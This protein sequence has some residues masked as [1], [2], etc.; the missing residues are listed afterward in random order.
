MKRI[1]AI[2]FVLCTVLF[3]CACDSS[4]GFAPKSEEELV[5]ESVE[6]RGG[7]EYIGTSIGGNKMSSSSASINTVRKVS[8]T[9]Y[10]VAGKLT[11]SDD[12]GNKWTNNFDCSVVYDSDSDTWDVESF[13]TP[14]SG[15]SKS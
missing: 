3:L 6:I 12:Y 14:T 13:D 15:W 8:D 11:M 5:R 4:S 9:E 2:F 7:L 1:A 10:Y